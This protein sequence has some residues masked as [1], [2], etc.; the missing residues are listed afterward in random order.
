M[1]QTERAMFKILISGVVTLLFTATLQEKE[2]FFS[3]FLM[4]SLFGSCLFPLALR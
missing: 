3:P 1:Y 4:I 2:D